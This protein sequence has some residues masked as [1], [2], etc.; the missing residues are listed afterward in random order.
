M[1]FFNVLSVILITLLVY[2]TIH[3]KSSNEWLCRWTLEEIQQ[4]TL[5][6]TQAKNRLGILIPQFREYAKQK[7][8]DNIVPVPLNNGDCKQ[9]WTGPGTGAWYRVDTNCTVNQYPQTT[10]RY[11]FPKIV[12]TSTG[13]S[14][15]GF[16]KSLGIFNSYNGEGT[17]IGFVYDNNRNTWN[18]YANDAGGWKSGN[19]TL[20]PLDNPCIRVS[21][22][23]LNGNLALLAISDDTT[24][25]LLNQ[26][27]F[28]AYS[29]LN[30]NDFGLNTGFYRFD[31]IA[32]NT[33]ETL[34]SGSVL[35]NS[36]TDSWTIYPYSAGS[37]RIVTDT[38]VAQSVRG[39][40]PGPCCSSEEM[41]TIT[42]TSQNN[43]HA[44]TVTIDYVS[45]P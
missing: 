14:K 29:E 30:L 11:C 42:V 22:H 13:K 10:I 17:D 32:Q 41:N 15:D 12:L 5:S 26:E 25:K 21:L 27:V 2:T 35:S 3:C 4:G 23:T 16:Y 38:L 1:Q 19:F 31:S 45:H 24:G 36:V 43:W 9:A 34:S 39:Y 20:H 33:P 6:V 18:T 7:I 37:P 8:V 40:K 28:K 44:S